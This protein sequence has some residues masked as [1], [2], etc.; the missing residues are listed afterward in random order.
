MG[1][2]IVVGTV[3]LA[4]ALVQKLGGGGA[5]AGGGVA[6][7]QPEGTAIQGVSAGDGVVAI[8]VRRPEGDRVLLLDPRRGTVTREIRLGE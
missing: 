3:G 4:I 6:L 5:T 8:W 2:L 1:V 7:H